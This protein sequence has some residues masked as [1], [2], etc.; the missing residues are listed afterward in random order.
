[1]CQVLEGSAHLLLVAPDDEVD[2]VEDALSPRE[3]DDPVLVLASAEAK[4]HVDEAGRPREAEPPA[5]VDEVV[6]RVCVGH[7]LPRAD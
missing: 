6:V 3:R 5:I 2:G 1:L 4:F 7:G